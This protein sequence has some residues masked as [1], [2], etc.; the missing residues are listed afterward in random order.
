MIHI[1]EQIVISICLRFKKT[2]KFCAILTLYI[3]HKTNTFIL[4]IYRNAVT[5]N[6]RSRLLPVGYFHLGDFI[7]SMKRGSLVMNHPCEMSCPI[8]NKPIL[9]G[10]Y[11]GSI[12]KLF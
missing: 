11:S 1:L 8:I 3:D 12:G 5:D 9:Y 10:S 2:R 4:Y 7:N 6:E